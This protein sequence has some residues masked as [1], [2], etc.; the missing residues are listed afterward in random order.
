MDDILPARMRRWLRGAAC[1]IAAQAALAGQDALVAAPQAYKLVF[2]NASLRVL[3]VHYGARGVVPSHEHPAHPALFVYLSDGGPVRFL[4]VGASPF[5]TTRPAVKLGAMRFTTGAA[6]VHQVISMSD[7]DDDSLRIE[8][9]L[10][11]PPGPVRSDR[12]PPLPAPPAGN[13]RRVRLDNEYARIVEIDCAAGTDCAGAGEAALPELL[14][15]LSAAR[16]AAGAERI[17]LAP[18]DVH[19][20][21][22]G[23]G[24]ALSNAGAAPAVLIAIDVKTPP[25]PR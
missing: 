2:E 6:E 18:G 5:E 25:G 22:A 11:S 16:I 21:D 3:R 17:D 1:L 13:A 19:W 7:T 24:K 23:A 4:H 15:A 12:M 8:W 20:F 14:V 10:P 9:R